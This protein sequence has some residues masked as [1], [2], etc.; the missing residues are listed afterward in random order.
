M[1]SIIE[2]PIRPLC[3]G[4]DDEQP[5]VYGLTQFPSGL[6]ALLRLDLKGGTEWKACAHSMYAEVMQGS[7]ERWT[8]LSIPL[9]WIRGEDRTEAP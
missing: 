1:S 5:F 6:Y 8:G 7:I 3:A 9:W 2:S 4:L